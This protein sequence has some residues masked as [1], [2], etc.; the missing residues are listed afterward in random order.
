MSQNWATR[1]KS[2]EINYD[3]FELIQKQLSQQYPGWW[4]IV[5]KGKLCGLGP[6]REKAYQ[7]ARTQSYYVVGEDCFCTSVS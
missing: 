7:D 1:E 2:M 4:V 6:T 3:H 5:Q